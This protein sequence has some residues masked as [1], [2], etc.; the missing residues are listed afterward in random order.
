ME[1]KV[2]AFQYGHHRIYNFIQ[3]T[4]YKNRVAKIWSGITRVNAKLGRIW[5]FHLFG[6]RYQLGK[7]KSD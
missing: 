6:K 3:I 5:I 4:S 2:K 7:L 1:F